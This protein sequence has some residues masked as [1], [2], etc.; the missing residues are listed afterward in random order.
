MATPPFKNIT[1]GQRNV[2]ACVKP[3]YVL[4]IGNVTI[5]VANNSQFNV[6]CINCKLSSCVTWLPKKQRVII[7]HQ[8]S[9]AM[10]P[11][12][13]S[14]EWYAD[15]GY[16]VLVKLEVALSRPIRAVGLI[17]AGVT[18]LIMLIASSVTAAISLSQTVQTATYVNSLSKNVST[19]LDTQEL[20]DQKLSTKIDALYE[21]VFW[22]GDEIQ[23][24]KVKTRLSCHAGYSWVCVTAKQYNQSEVPWDK[25]K[26][27][28]LGIW[29]H[30]NVTLNLDTVFP[31]LYLKGCD[32][33]S[34]RYLW[35]NS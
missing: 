3:P 23:A 30:K 29:H 7:L 21:V 15:K 6:S 4:L 2:T 14:G 11:V 26:K 1:I 33:G 8:P 35:R 20:I 12:N 17:I 25:V 19:A 27:H 22:M 18:A 24:L 32:R 28:L 16:Q 5:H 13:V 31:P 9:F 34:H 10:L